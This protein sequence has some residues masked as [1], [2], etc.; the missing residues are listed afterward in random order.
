MKENSIREDIE[1]LKLCFTNQCNICGRYEKEECMLERNR[2]E[3]HILS[4]YKRVLEMNKILLKENEELKQ[5]K[6]NNHKMIALAQNEA[7][8]YM[9]GYE[10]GKN[11]RTSAIASIVENQQYYII[12]KQIEKYKENIKKLQTENEILKEENE[13]LSTEV[14]S[15][16]KEYEK[17]KR[18]AEINLKNAEEFKNNMCEHR[19]LLKS[20]NEIL[21]KE[22]EELKNAVNI[23]NKEKSDWIRAYQE[24]KDKQFELLR[25]SIPVKEVK[26]K[27][28]ELKENIQHLGNDGIELTYKENQEAQID[29]LQELIE[30]RK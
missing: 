19:C 25:S 16:K 15:S 23:V 27:I 20:E 4:D 24:E 1:R 13:Q 10:D 12:R 7:L 29:V 9:Q 14:N 18:L 5:E 3:Q 30:G 22:N 21:Q 2:C 28:E 6:I 17:Y 11:S 26:D 8:G